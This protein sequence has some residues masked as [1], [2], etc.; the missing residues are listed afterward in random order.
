MKI[1]ITGIGG[2]LGS[3]L[4]DALIADG[5]DVYGCDNLVG[6]EIENVPE[7]ATF[8]VADC[9]DFDAMHELTAGMDVVYHC[10]ALAY[11]G[12]SVFSPALIADNIL[13]ASATVFS[14]SIA[15]GVKRIIYCSSMAR[16]GEAP[17]PFRETMPCAPCDPYGICKLAAENLL[18]NLAH[19]H[20]IEWNIA[21]P[22]NIIGPRQRIDPY[23]NVAAIMINRALR[24]EPPIIY[25]D[26][27]Q[28]RCFSW[29]GDAVQCLVRM[30]DP[31][32]CGE[33]INIGPDEEPVTIN[34]LAH[35]VADKT[36][37][38]MP[39]VYMAGRPGEVRHALCSSDKARVLLGYRTT[40]TL[41]QSIEAMV[42]HMR[43]AGSRPFDYH[44][45]LE[46]I[47]ERTPLTWTRK[48]I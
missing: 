46:I 44:L 15:N 17:T 21:V 10:A 39:P 8:T 33:V 23:R 31:V 9:G 20:G 11:E 7:M 18:I 2:F 45:S 16:Y 41:A 34:E 4:A 43:A 37:I 30:L 28:K 6:G 19:H 42:A 24:F 35:V 25:G 48:L 38:T 36:G 29:V 47:T 14:A 5:Y 26:G 32:I 12:L 13:A 27:E 22:H 3:H 1:F 40:K